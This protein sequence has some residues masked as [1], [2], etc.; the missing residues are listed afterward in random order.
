MQLSQVIRRF[1]ARM[2][3]GFSALLSRTGA[4]PLK[5]KIDSAVLRRALAVFPALIL[6]YYVVGAL[7]SHKID[8]DPRFATDPAGRLPNDS[9]AVG[10][11]I[12]LLDREVNRNGWVANAPFYV[13]TA[14]LHNMAS[15]Q[16]GIVESITNLADGLDAVLKTRGTNSVDLEVTVDK[17]SKRPDV[18]SWD[19]SEPWGYLGNSEREY[20]E[21]LLDLQGYNVAV[22]DGA[23]IYPRDAAA[24]IVILKRFS[25]K[26]QETA[27]ALDREAAYRPLILSRRLG[28][29]FYRTRGNA[30]CQMVLLRGLKTDF[31]DLIGARNLGAAWDR[32]DTAL[33]RVALYSPLFLL[34]GAPDSVLLPSHPLI[35][36][37]Y[38]LDAERALQDLIAK[39]S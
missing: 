5:L 9:Y 14:L 27:I 7:W 11:A 36:S 18:W 34:N 16:T 20:R 13:P 37:Y 30:Y 38:A 19:W 21:G 2:S 28:D 17:L 32:A 1:G 26:L 22:S 4:E 10:L 39:L 8:D 25:G 12:G 24:L 6:L 35:A 3:A 29:A 33:R 15:Y 31:A 23:S